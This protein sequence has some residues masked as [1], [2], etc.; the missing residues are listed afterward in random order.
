MA[1]IPFA[2]TFDGDKMTMTYITPNKKIF[3]VFRYCGLCMNTYYFCL[4][5]SQIKVDSNG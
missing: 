3:N 1:A 5:K 2:I 4:T